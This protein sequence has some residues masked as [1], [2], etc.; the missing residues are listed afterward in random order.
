MLNNGEGI[1]VDYKESIKYYKMA[2]DK[3]NS[4]AMYNYAVMLKNGQGVPIDCREVTK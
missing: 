4:D 2:I 1:P 3:G